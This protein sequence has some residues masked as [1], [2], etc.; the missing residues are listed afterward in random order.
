MIEAS[1]YGIDLRLPFALRAD[2]HARAVSRDA[3]PLD[4]VI[5]SV[6]KRG[7]RVWVST[8]PPHVECWY[9]G[10]TVS[11]HW[12]QA[13]F[14]IDEHRIVID[15]AEPAWAFERF[16]NPVMSLAVAGR[17]GVAFHGFSAATEVGTVAVMGGSGSGKSSLGR[18]LLD[19]GARLVTDDVI[20]FDADGRLQPGAAYIRVETDDPARRDPGGKRRLHV[21][22]VEG[23]TEL[24]MVVV[25][26]RD[27]TDI[28]RLTRST[29]AIDRLL[30]QIYNPAFAHPGQRGRNLAR[31]ARLVESSRV[32]GYPRH[33]LPVP[34]LA[35]LTDRLLRDDGEAQ[36]TPTR[37]EGLA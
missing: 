20:V 15:A 5:D 36:L 28:R 14:A 7:S 6:P 31:A 19:R 8:R 2:M 23:P 18:G 17:G 24:D 34:E 13:S 30:S 35:E 11:L 10:S 21:D 1:L 22:S 16:H 33:H 27:F 37:A 3:E 12:E 25:L 29:V 9:H 26:S 32:Y 4:V